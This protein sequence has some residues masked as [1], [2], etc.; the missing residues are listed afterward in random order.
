MSITLEQTLLL[1]EGKRR[2]PYECSEGKLTIGVGRN[3][4]DR[5]LSDDEIDYLLKND[6][7]T[8][9]MELLSDREVGPIYQRL[10]ET[11]QIAIKNMAFNLGL[12]R[13][14]GFRRMWAALASGDYSEAA[15]EAKDSRWYHQVGDRG[16]RI[17]S[18][19]ETG[20]LSAYEDIL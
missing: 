12:P 20:S 9:T 13:L 4:E 5:G 3:L 14:K 7:R 16:D 19:I 1:D 6:I 11:R 8:V 18:V 17:A 10:D 15:V 2:M